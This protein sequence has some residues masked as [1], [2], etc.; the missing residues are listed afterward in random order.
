MTR[1]EVSSANLQP[2]AFLDSNVLVRLFHFWDACE[3]ANVRLD[4]VS[5]WEELK[6]KLEV[7]CV[8]AGILSGSDA[9][10]VS[11]GMKSFQHLKATKGDYKIV[12]SRVCWSEAHHV[13]LE[14]RGL[15]RLVR[16]GV[17]YSFRMKRPQ[18]LYRVS[19]EGKDYVDLDNQLD[20]F[21]HCLDMDYGIKVTSVEES[22]AAGLEINIWVTAKLIWS[23]VL[24]S[25]IDA[26]VYAASI[27]VGADVFITA[28]SSLR[29]ALELLYKPDDDWKALV[30]SLK[31]ELDVNP[32]TEFPQPLP[33]TTELPNISVAM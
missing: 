25:V 5:K 16:L 33:A 23:H 6:A 13:L 21:Q 7:A 9:V 4:A 8:P 28:D 2:I 19:L 29:G 11:A 14:Q 32:N 22:L 12:T 31:E 20:A 27:L 30:E 26:Y 1:I 15:E 10:D 24:M 18:A 3:S 17:P